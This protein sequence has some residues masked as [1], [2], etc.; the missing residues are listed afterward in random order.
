MGLSM[1]FQLDQPRLA[2][3]TV[4][5]VMRPQTGLILTK[6]LYRIG[7]TVAGILVSFV[8]ISCFAQERVLFLLGLAL[9]VAFCT[10]GAAF[11]RDFKSYGFVLA[12]YVAVL[13]GLMAAPQP[14][15]FFPFAVTRLSEVTLG[16][17]CAGLINDIIFPQRLSDQ[18]FRT[19]QTRYADFIAFIHASLSGKATPSQLANMQLKLVGNVVALESIR[20]AAIF[21]DPEVRA[22]DKKIQGLNSTFMAASTTFYSFHQ[23]LTRLTRNSTSAGAALSEIYDSL[24]Q[25]LVTTAAA[26]SSAAGARETARHIAA[27]RTM[28]SKKAAS[29]KKDFP[30]LAEPENSVDFET[31]IELLHRFLHELHTYTRVYA[32]LADK[33]QE[34]NS[35]DDMSFITHTD[36]L[37][38]FLAGGRAFIAVALVSIFWIATAWPYGGSMLSFVAVTSALFGSV[39]DQQRGVRHMTIGHG[40]GFVAAFLFECFILPSL[41]GFTL[42]CTA[43][44]PFLMIGP[45]IITYPR[46]AA[47]GT[48]YVVF[49]C[50]MLSPTNPMVFNPVGI[51]NEGPAALAGSLIAGLVFMTLIPVNGTWHKR[52]MARQIR[53][54]VVLACFGQLNGLINRFEGGTYDLLHK[55][56]GSKHLAEDGNQRLV[57]WIFTVREIGRAL[58]HVREQAAKTPLSPPL[59]HMVQECVRSTARLFSKVSA[60]RRNAALARVGGTIDALHGEMEAASCTPSHRNSIILLLTSL[61]LVRTALLDEETILAATIGGPPAPSKEGIT[62]AA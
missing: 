21:E 49:F 22:R 8:L 47:I 43:L 14:L 55:L 28:L 30:A 16:I 44:V 13:A 11:Y 53:Q 41:D 34:L 58:I 26:P 33:Q 5:I 31:A 59:A 4:F 10:A 24:G 20:S 36:P 56:D 29:V 46:W 60:R 1:L 54:Q 18:L 61:H 27:F 48:G 42:L 62:H 50:A 38:A 23:L 45:Y 6:S 7:G 32:S 25:T 35:A 12:G 17:I 19:V 9:W 40:S 2:M 37:A 39:P 51:L 15:A 57:A 3:I 52:R